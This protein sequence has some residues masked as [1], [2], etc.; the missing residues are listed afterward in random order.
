MKNA[1]LYLI[2]SAL[3]FIASAIYG[4]D[5]SLGAYICWLMSAFVLGM[6]ISSF[7]TE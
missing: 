1:P 3:F 7:F 5:K 6:A 4:D 2:A